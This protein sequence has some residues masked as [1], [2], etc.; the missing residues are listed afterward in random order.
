MVVLEAATVRS[1]DQRRR[2]LELKVQRNRKLLRLQMA[3]LPLHL[4]ADEEGEVEAH[5]VEGAE[6]LP[7]AAQSVVLAGV[8]AEVEEEEEEE[9][10]AQEQPVVLRLGEACRWLG[11]QR[12]R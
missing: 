10:Q 11:D 3:T 6:H 1:Q 9:A 2:N 4:S 8:E 12:A 5:E 7:L